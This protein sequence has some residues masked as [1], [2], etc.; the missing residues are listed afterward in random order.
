MEIAKEEGS[1]WLFPG[2]RPKVAGNEVKHLSKHVLTRAFAL[3]PNVAAS[4]HDVR[5]SMG[6]LGESVLGLM[7]SDTK[8]ILDHGEGVPSGD[9]TAAHYSLHDGRHFKWP[10]MDRWVSE[11]EAQVADA[12]AEDPL[13]R[14]SG[15]LKTQI[16]LARYGDETSP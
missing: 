5:R 9:V 6:T 1:I 13:L 15:W 11:V 7:R 12:V 8:A 3:M 16:D 4:P 14:D 2:F 10:V